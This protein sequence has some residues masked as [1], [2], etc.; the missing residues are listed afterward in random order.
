MVGSGGMTSDPDADDAVRALSAALLTLAARDQRT[1]CQGRYSELWTSE[2][3]T[4]RAETI[5]LCAGCDLITKC[6]DYAT[7]LK[8][9][10][11]VWAG[12]DRTPSTRTTP[13]PP[14]EK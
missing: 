3:Y 10:F 12:V 11:G 7:E 14:K 1:P 13:N 6:A 2:D 8:A 9:S 4:Q 5:P